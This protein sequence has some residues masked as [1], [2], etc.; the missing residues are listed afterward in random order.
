MDSELLAEMVEKMRLRENDDEKTVLSKK[1]SYVLRHGAKQLD[2][3]M[4]DT[5]FVPVNALL[6][7]K[8]IFGS[9][10]MKDFMQF[11]MTSNMDKQRYEVVVK[12]YELLIRATGKHS[13]Q[14]Q[15]LEPKPP[16]PDRKGKKG[17][18]SATGPR[19]GKASHLVT[20]DEFCTIWRLDRQARLRLS[21][22]S[23][24]NR[25]MAIE[26]FSPPSH[27]PASDYSKV[28]VAFCNRFKR[29][30]ENEGKPMPGGGNLQ[31]VVA[32]MVRSQKDAPKPRGQIEVNLRNENPTM[33]GLLDR[34]EAGHGAHGMNFRTPGSSPRSTGDQP[35]LHPDLAGQ[36]GGWHRQVDPEDDWIEQRPRQVQGV[37]Q[38]HSSSF[39]PAP[40]PLQQQSQLQL[41]Q[42]AQQQGTQVQMNLQQLPNQNQ[43]Q[44]QLQQ[45]VLQQQ[46][47]M[48]QQR[49]QLLERQL[50]QLQQQRLNQ[51]PGSGHQLGQSHQQYGAGQQEQFLQMLKQGPASSA[52]TANP[53][54]EAGQNTGLVLRMNRQPP[55]PPPLEAPEVR[56]LGQQPGIPHGVQDRQML[57]QYGQGTQLG[58]AGN[59]TRS[60]GANWGA[61]GD[62]GSQQWNQGNQSGQRWGHTQAD[63]A[64]S[65]GMGNS[66]CHA[67]GVPAAPGNWGETVGSNVGPPSRGPDASA[68][69]SRVPGN[70]GMQ[71]SG[72]ETGMET[73][74]YGGGGSGGCGGD[75]GGCAGAFR[76]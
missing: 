2:L 52:L 25:M 31:A 72:Y 38:A 49:Q 51:F 60:S 66:Q 32:Q 50:Q 40:P 45:L 42:Q 62:H 64:A 58:P 55:P 73:Y 61:Y 3:E 30:Q 70:W 47:A 28:F 15:G 6:E 35:N 57:G 44:S 76:V 11:V 41:L 16:K 8:D 22:L 18:G 68:R 36:P 69:V 14:V 5:G 37:Q 4:T 67:A 20:D 56:S 12:D 43:Q 75:W 53:Q 59:F 26:Q 10:T 54:V 7:I 24:G 23:P 39:H 9:I 21:E 1:L 17:S 46:I 65:S 27:V 34:F 71:A 33:R 19:L 63:Q 74:G 48:Q 29:K 13:V